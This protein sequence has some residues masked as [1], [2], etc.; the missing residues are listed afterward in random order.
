[1]ITVVIPTHNSAHLIG[2]CLTSLVTAAVDGL[3]RE[4]VMADAGS[5]DGTL[6][7]AEDCGAR[8]V[9]DGDDAG[10]RLA[11]ACAR[12]RGDW[13]MV[14]E[15]DASFPDGWRLAV[16]RQINRGWDR[17]ASLPRPG[18]A[19]FRRPLAPPQGLLLSARLYQSSGGF[20]AGDRG[21]AR[22]IGAVRAKRL[23]W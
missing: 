4:V 3:V 22:L 17:A 11:A 18:L 16:E 20:R 10:A 12:P 9:T 6:D 15:P 23:V 13:L 2:P 1:M 7:I 21:F 14:L 8:I 19:W 5:T